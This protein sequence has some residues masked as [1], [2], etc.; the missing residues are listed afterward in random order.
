MSAVTSHGHSQSNPCRNV[1]CCLRRDRADR[2]ATHQLPYRLRICSA[3]SDCATSG[4]AFLVGVLGAPASAA[5]W[6]P[7]RD[8]QY[9]AAASIARVR[10]PYPPTL[11]PCY[12]PCV[13]QQP[14]GCST[15]WWGCPVRRAAPSS[16]PR[17]ERAQLPH[18]LMPLA[19]A[20]YRSGGADDRSLSSSFGATGDGMQAAM[21]PA[22]AR[23]LLVRL[24]LA[25]ARLLRRVVVGRQAAQWRLR[26]PWRLE[27]RPERRFGGRRQVS[28]AAPSNA[29]RRV[30]L[31]QRCGGR[32]HLRHRTVDTVSKFDE[33]KAMLLA[34]CRA[35]TEQ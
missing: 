11:R 18:M 28:H 17:P 26:G 20:R 29:R 3:L 31:T 24:S 4:T 34:L 32:E 22:H 21:G 13:A 16:T 15:S 33:A 1:Q 19:R 9:S 12:P 14:T 6:S 35:L 23:V 25:H 2:T 5:T 27:R 30:Q 8:L 7:T 10:I